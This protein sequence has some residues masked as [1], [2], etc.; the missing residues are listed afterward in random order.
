MSGSLPFPSAAPLGPRFE[1]DIWC[2]KSGLKCL[3]FPNLEPGGSSSARIL[4][5]KHF[6]YFQEYVPRY[7]VVVKD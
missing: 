2:K 4:G 1:V 5:A 7:F 3:K 6:F